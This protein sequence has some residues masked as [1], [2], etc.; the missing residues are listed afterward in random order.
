[1]RILRKHIC[2]DGASVGAIWHSL[3][4]EPLLVSEWVII[5]KPFVIKPLLVVGPVGIRTL[6]A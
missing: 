6:V 4:V 2:A 5:V 3:I 1:M